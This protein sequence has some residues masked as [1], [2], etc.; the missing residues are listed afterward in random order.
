MHN[1]EPEGSIPNKTAPPDMSQLYNRDPLTE[2]EP[3]KNSTTQ[4]QVRT[5]TITAV[6]T[7]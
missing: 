7:F 1:E 3:I 6:Q 2:G 4:L 5:A